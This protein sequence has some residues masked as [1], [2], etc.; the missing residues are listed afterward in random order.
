M[1]SIQLL[2][3]ESGKRTRKVSTSLNPSFQSVLV[4]ADELQMQQ[5]GSGGGAY[6]DF[7]ARN[8]RSSASP[9]NANDLVNK[10]ALDAAVAAIPQITE[11]QD[12]VATITNT[13]PG[14]PV[15]GDR[16][17]VGTSG[18][19]A[20]SGQNNKIAEYDGAAWQFT[21]P[22]TGTFLSV[23]DVANAIYYYGGSSWDAKQF[24]STTASN[25]LK[26]VGIDIQR[27]DAVSKVNDNAGAITIRQVVYVKANGNVD[28]ASKATANLDSFD[29]G[30]V[31]D[32]TIAS[33]ATGKIIVRNGA[34]VSGF[35]GLTPGQ[36]YYVAASGTID[37]YAN[38]TWNIGDHVY[39]VGRAVTS[40]DLKLDQEFEYV[41]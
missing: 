35:T 39:R 41:Y 27:D 23:D 21:T 6:F 34:I 22:T 25:G 10:A 31:E 13:P 3:V 38:I 20:F 12:S 17:L 24:E 1:A 30:L 18:T 37:T 15:L 19:G 26:K 40:S 2:V 5:G 36:A 14:S 11:W 33:S 4:G 29:I 7:G 8:L 16:V 32:A 28:L 9:S